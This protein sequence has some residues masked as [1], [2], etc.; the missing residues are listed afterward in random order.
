MDKS[1]LYTATVVDFYFEVMMAF[2]AVIGINSE[3]LVI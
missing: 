3:G 2:S 1:K